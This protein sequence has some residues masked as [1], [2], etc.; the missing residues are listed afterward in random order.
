MLLGYSLAPVPEW[1]GP[2]RW[3][4]VLLVSGWVA[5][6]NGA[7]A[8]GRA[9][10]LAFGLVALVSLR[11]SAPGAF[12][13]SGEP[14]LQVRIV[15]TGHPTPRRPA[16]DATANV[17]GRLAELSQGADVD[18]IVWPENA[19][20]AVMPANIARIRALRNEVAGDAAVLFGA[21]HIPAGQRPRLFTSAVLLPSEGEP[22]MYDKRIRIPFFEY[23][24]W[25]LP[26]RERGSG[27]S[28]GSSPR[29]LTVGGIRLAP[30]ICYEALFSEHARHGA[31]DGADLLVHLSNEA[32]F[33][34]TRGA[35][36]L[37]AAA[38]F[39]AVETGRPILRSTN[40]GVSGLVHP[41]GRIARRREGAAGS[42]DVELRAVAGTPL[43]LRIG[44]GWWWL[45]ALAAI[46]GFVAE[47]RRP[48]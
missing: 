19:V 43:A 38:V 7:W 20:P 28:V 42:F 16:S 46:L 36:Q 5:L 25:P 8:M 1:I 10:G 17:I 21:T 12:V 11:A 4:G 27:I 41:D 48:T 24:P 32:W 9:A 40:A 35:D 34:A 13:P 26:S 39:R 30:L 29:I 2:A 44:N 15:H 47:R 45:A 33:G 37:L 6:A 18:L 23:A 31:L 3:G 22:R 14:S